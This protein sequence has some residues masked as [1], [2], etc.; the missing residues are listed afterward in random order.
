MQRPSG[1]EMIGSRIV[2]G[3]FVEVNGSGEEEPAAGQG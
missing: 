1:A 2:V 3:P